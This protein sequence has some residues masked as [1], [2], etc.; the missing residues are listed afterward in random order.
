MDVLYISLPH[1]SVTIKNA[2][3][4]ITDDL[5]I[6]N[7]LIGITT[8]NEAKMIVATRKVKESLE[9]SGFKH[10]RCIAH[11]L[12]LIVK[13]AFET[14]FILTVYLLKNYVLLLVQLEIHPNKWIS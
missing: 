10:Y 8:D 5:N 7:R 1:D 12:N 11:I 4:K 9:L 13:A 2:I 3:L 14:N 6:T